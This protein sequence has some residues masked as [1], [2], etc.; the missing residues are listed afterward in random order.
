ME[1]KTKQNKKNTSTKNDQVLD[2]KY[3]AQNIEACSKSAVLHMCTQPKKSIC[4]PNTALEK[5][6]QSVSA[7]DF[8]SKA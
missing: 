6:L 8:G 1:A 7:C 2:L 4:Y 5:M 3:L